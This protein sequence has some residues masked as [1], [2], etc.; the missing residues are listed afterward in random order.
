MH[1]KTLILTGFKSFP[2]RVRLEFNTGVT[3]VVGPNGSGKSNISD[4]IRWVLGEQSAKSLRGSKMED[5][6]FSGTEYRRSL[7]YA[8]VSMVI[9]NADRRMNSE[10]TEITVSR[11][12]YRS[13]EGEYRINGNSCR[14][15]DV[16]ELFMDTGVGREGYSIIGQGKIE[17]ILSARSDDRRKLF[18]EAAGIVKYKT[19]RQEALAK[20]ERERLNLDRV[21]DII[22]ELELQLAPMAEQ[23]DAAKLFLSLKEQLKTIQVSIFLVQVESAE[24]QLSE[25][26]ESIRLSSSQQESERAK[27]ENQNSVFN[28]LQIDLT[29]IEEQLCELN[30]KKDCIQSH[31]K[32]LEVDIKV[33]EERI[34]NII[35]AEERLAGQIDKN[36]DISAKKNGMLTEER[37][38]EAALESDYAAVCVRLEATQK[39]YDSFSEG[40]SEKDQGLEQL[41][42]SLM[43]RIKASLELKNKMDRVES[44][45][46]LL[47]ESRGKLFVEGEACDC[48]VVELNTHLAKERAASEN[49]LNQIDE[50]LSK[51][52]ELQRNSEVLKSQLEQASEREAEAA[53]RLSKA[54]SRHSVLLDMES[55]FEGYRRSSKTILKH[56]QEL[57][58]IIGAVGELTRTPVDFE[59]AIETAL[60]SSLHDIITETDEDALAAIEY[61]KST[62]EGRATFLPLNTVKPRTLGKDKEAIL[63]EPGI[64]GIACELISYEP[65]YERVF[66]HLLGAIVVADNGA[67]AASVSKKYKNR[68]IIVSLDGELF[69]SSGTITGGS[70]N[71][72][73]GV[74]GRARELDELKCEIIKLQTD[75]DTCAQEA[76]RIKVQ[77]DDETNETEKLREQWQALLLENNTQ[78]NKCKQLEESSAE[79]NNKLRDISEECEKLTLKKA[80]TNDTFAMLQ[81][82]FKTAEH[83]IET[84]RL[85]LDYYAKS[86][87]GDRKKHDEH[88][89]ALTE[90][91]IHTSRIEQQLQICREGASSIELE[92]QS[93]LEDAEALE[94]DLSSSVAE[95]QQLRQKVESMKSELNTSLT[96]QTELAGQIEKSSVKKDTFRRQISEIERKQRITTEMLAG[97][98]TEVVKLEMRKEQIE[99]DT[100]RL[101]DN[102]WDEYKLTVQTAKDIKTIDQSLN[103]LNR[104]ER[105]LKNEI[106]GIGHV[107][108]GAIEEYKAV[109]SRYQ[110]LIGQRSDIMEAEEKLLSVISELSELMERQFAEQFSVISQNFSQVFR[111]MFSGGKARLILSEARNILESGIEIEVQPPGKNL[112]SMSLLSGGERAL[113]AAALLFSILRLKPSPFCVLDEIEAALD[114]VNTSRFAEYIRRISNETQFILITHRKGTMLAA[115]VLYGVTMQEAG[116]S[117]LVSL[118]LEDEASGEFF[119]KNA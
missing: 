56:K 1:L 13:G 64:L 27:L 43:D 6:I 51:I 45:M 7:G 63:N 58:G 84:N 2:E 94:A 41:N 60:G 115:D 49:T 116:V 34:I 12:M 85:E 119:S 114:E 46:E 113:T 75:V 91:K 61:L 105:R 90:L 10:Y 76:A 3:A 23:A 50:Q 110:F 68:L 109:D 17:E 88:V 5:I 42:N 4:A 22:D 82:E 36:K 71:T 69:S 59:Y 31:S 108:V 79:L 26:N 25:L 104:E 44:Q 102:M 96:I 89:Q 86:I 73:T 38:R 11:R 77:I 37:K 62:R 52:Q 15:K 106:A 67:S 40:L 118:R 74:I 48:Q 93:I 81:N 55:G 117:K 101:Y 54:Q 39:N 103:S 30:E 100:R 95:R 24:K 29:N 57:R 66:L 111:D 9:D 72:N 16:H 53:K 47:E 92:I 83:D 98:S 20:L 112:Q 8:E 32:Q 99:A 28:R 21:T 14:L 87:T 97:L 33:T 78:Q 18:E 80:E 65:E 19:R 107:N 35:K 70:K